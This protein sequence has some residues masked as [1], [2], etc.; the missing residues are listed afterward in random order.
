MRTKSFKNHFPALLKLTGGI[1]LLLNLLM[2]ATPSE[3]KSPRERIRM[4]DDWKFM[5]GD[6]KEAAAPQFDDRSWRTVTLPHDWSI[7]SK[8][9][10]NEPSDGGGGFYPTGI[11]WYRKHLEIPK[12]WQGKRIEI[13]FEGIYQKSEIYLNGQK[14]NFRPYGYSTFFVDLT[15]SLK[16]GSSNLLSVR[17]DNS[18]HPN[19]RWYSGSGIY[20]HVW[21]Q[22]TNPTRI[23]NWG[24][25]VQCPEANEG[26]AQLSISTKLSNPL[27][28]KMEIQFQ[29]EILGPQRESLGKIEGTTTL[30]PGGEQEIAQSLS[31]K[32]PPLWFPEKPQMSQVITRVYAKQKLLDTVVT[33]FG[34]RHLAWSAKEGLT[35]NG[36]GYKLKGGCIHADNGVLGACAFDRAEERKI[37]ILKAAGFNAIRTSHHPFSPALLDACDR[38]GMLVMEN[39]FDCWNS[40]KR[41]N[42]Y[43][44]FFDE[45]WKRDLEEMILRDR[46]HPSIVLW[47]LG[48]EIRDIFDDPNVAAY[49]P[50]L[51]G[52]VHSLDRSRPATIGARHYPEE[53]NIKLGELVWRDQDVIGSNYSIGLLLKQPEKF[54]NLPLIST[55]SFRT[56]G[57]CENVLTQPNVIGD[58]V[59]TAQDYLGESGCG[60]WTYRT[61]PP[62]SSLLLPPNQPDDAVTPAKLEPHKG[63]KKDN[64]LDFWHGASC[65]QID[66]LGNIKSV[67]KRWNVAWK[68]DM[69]LGMVVRQP[70]TQSIEFRPDNS[71]PI[72]DS[73]TWPGWENKLVEVEV[74]SAY[75]KTRLYLNDKLVAER[76]TEDSMCRY[77]LP[78][79]R[80]EL[81]AVGLK[82]GK[83]VESVK[84]IT[85]GETKTIRLQ[86]DRTIITADGQGLV[87]IQVE[88]VDEQGRLQP[89]SDRLVQFTV[90]GPGTIAGLGNA[91]LRDP[92]SY[93]GTECHLY[94]GQALVVLRSNHEKGTLT[95]QC[96]SPGLASSEI[97]IKTQ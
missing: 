72:F 48:N 10:L 18:L 6:I 93:Q 83:E 22:A 52:V 50:K 60:K 20:R 71:Y 68:T 32:N 69:K 94:H 64:P 34:F 17:V 95:L 89:N 87:F 36:E 2:G 51:L 56:L 42:D 79:Q 21:L 3:I 31:I 46:N 80:G 5:R 66:I 58:F 57:Q 9:D 74:Y 13:E 25:F 40:Q 15:P 92:T 77:Q 90:K 7:E 59:W 35:I 1:L 44:L 49:A 43:H 62:K 47:D 63:G 33:P 26:H 12:E 38:L 75:D 19:T 53:K 81:K 37:E 16:F 82:E 30:A 55:E 78:Y 76:A 24:V 39:S 70:G 4:D 67:S 14:I 97:Q 28:E 73:W 65:G 27:T 29:S 54:S 61:E 11:A 96:K 86:P 85:A 84:L 8:P 91:N 23:N 88:A 45:W 41:S